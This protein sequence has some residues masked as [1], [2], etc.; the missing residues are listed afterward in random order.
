MVANFY[1]A[2]KKKYGPS[3]PLF[4]GSVDDPLPQTNLTL[5]LSARPRRRAI[6]TEA[7]H[8]DHRQSP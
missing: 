7:Q 8:A 4:G 1:R 3:N 6:N 5:R 2:R